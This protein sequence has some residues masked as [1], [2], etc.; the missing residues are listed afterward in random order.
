MKAYVKIK[1]G[2]EKSRIESFG[3]WRYLVYLKEVENSPEAMKSF[4]AGFSKFIGAR[5]KDIKYSGRSSDGN[6]VFE[7]NEK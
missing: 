4:L 7:I 5:E 3:N 2:A 1:F 6:Y